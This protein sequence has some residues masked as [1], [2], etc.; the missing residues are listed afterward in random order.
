MVSLHNCNS[1]DVNKHLTSVKETSNCVVQLILK[2]FQ[3][4]S[5]ITVNPEICTYIAEISAPPALMKK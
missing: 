1:S 4:I 2:G 3:Q 5:D